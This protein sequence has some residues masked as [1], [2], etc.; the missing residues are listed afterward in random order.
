M[1]KFRRRVSA[2]NADLTTPEIA[3]MPFFGSM[4]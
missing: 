3:S 1:F 2:P 4:R